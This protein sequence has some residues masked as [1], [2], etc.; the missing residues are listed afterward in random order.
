MKIY[1]QRLLLID[2]INN[3]HERIFILNCWNLRLCNVL[4][5]MQI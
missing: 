5:N 4:D 2:I 1:Y 3:Y